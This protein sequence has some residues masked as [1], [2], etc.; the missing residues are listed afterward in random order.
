M[1]NLEKYKEKLQHIKK[2]L[3]KFDQNSLDTDYSTL[4]ECFDICYDQNIFDLTMVKSDLVD[5]YKLA[6]FEELTCVSGALSFLSIQI[7]AANFIMSNNNFKLKDKYISKKCGIAINHLRAPLTIVS[8]KPCKG[9]FKLNGELTW[10][11]GYKIFDTLLIG[12]HCD[13]FEFEGMGAFESKDGF[14]I[15]SADQTFVG[16][17]LNTVNIKL[18]DFFISDEDIVSKKE[19][20]SYTRAKSASKTV[21]FCIYSLGLSALEFSDDKDFKYISI[22]KLENIKKRFWDSKDPDELDGLR[23]ELFNLVQ[24]IITVAMVLNGGK[25]ILLNSSLQRVYR[26]LIMF[27]SN[28]LNQ[29]LKDIFKNNFISH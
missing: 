18:K 29:K 21:H 1:Q 27:N 14:E 11:S 22:K 13:G 5:E 4:K 17:S 28:G 16:Y 8:A 10:A 26:E 7:L 20:G 24:D 25:S 2:R 9:G 12:F 3:K 23:V 6:L 15:G 19:I